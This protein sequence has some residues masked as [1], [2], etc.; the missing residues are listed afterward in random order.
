MDNSFWE[1]VEFEY[2][3]KTYCYHDLEIEGNAEVLRIITEARRNVTELGYW[4]DVATGLSSLVGNLCNQIK[5]LQ[6]VIGDLKNEE[7]ANT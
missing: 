7:T 3:D 4:R 5:R 2:R 1:T 6:K